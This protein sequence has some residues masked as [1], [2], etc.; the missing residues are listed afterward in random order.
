M[1][2]V[3]LALLAIASA[4]WPTLIAIDIVAFRTPRPATLLAWFLAASLATTIAE[5]LVIVFALEGTKFASPSHRSVGGWGNLIGGIAALLA[6]YLLRVRTARELPTAKQG[7]VKP[8]PWTERIVARGGVYAF[9]AGVV[10]NLF[11]GIFPLVALRLIAGF[12]YSEGIKVVLVVGFY[13]CMFVIIEAPLLG[14]LFAP[15]RVEPRVHRLNRWLDRNGKRLAV[16]VLAVAG[17]LLLVR[18]ILQL[19]TA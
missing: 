8:P 17:L 13:L 19:A 15:E 18:G 1:D 5:G 11:P 14:L 2:L 12:T 16:E 7:E 4:F 6:A 3:E 10:L 9:C